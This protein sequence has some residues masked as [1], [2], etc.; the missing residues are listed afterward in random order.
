M[1]QAVVTLYEFIENIVGSV[2]AELE[3]LIYVILCLVFFYILYMFFNL[4]FIVFGVTKW[5]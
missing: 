2:P 5:R 1:S 3:S 4:L